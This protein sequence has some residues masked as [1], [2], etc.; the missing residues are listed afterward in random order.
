MCLV[1]TCLCNYS[2]CACTCSGTPCALSRR[3]CSCSELPDLM[4]L[5]DEHTGVWLLITNLL[6][7]HRVHLTRYFWEAL[8]LGQVLPREPALD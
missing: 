8:K 6:R 7:L 3:P 5:G 1:N 2:D 4:F